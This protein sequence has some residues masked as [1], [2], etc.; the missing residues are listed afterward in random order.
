MKLAHTGWGLPFLLW[1][2]LGLAESPLTGF[3]SVA[4]GTFRSGDMV[5]DK[6]RHLVRVEQFEILDH[7]VTN[8]EYKQF[9]VDTGYRPPL[10]WVNGE[11]PD[12]K[13]NHPVVFVNIKDADQ[14]LRWLTEKEQRFYRLP[15]RVEFEYAARGGVAEKLYPWGDDDPAGRANYDADGGRRFDRWQDYLD[16]VRRGKPNGL[17]LYD[18]AGNVWQMVR[19]DV[20]PVISRY[21]YRFEDTSQSENIRGGNVVGG[22]WARGAEYLRCGFS[23]YFNMGNRHPD[24]GFRPVRE[25]EGADWRVEPRKLTALSKG[26]GQVFLSWARLKGDAK[27]TRFNVYRIDHGNHAGFLVNEKPLEESTTFLDTQREVGRRYTYYLRPVNREGQEG[28]CSERVGVTVSEDVRGVVATFRPGYVRGE[29]VPVFGDLDGDGALDCV[30]RLDN[31]NREMSQDL[32]IPVTLEAFT[33][34]GRPLWRREVCDHDHCF[35]NANNV[36]FGVWDM[37]GDGRAEVITRLQMGDDVVVAI[38]DGLTGRLKCNARWPDMVS[39]FVLSSTRI[40]LSIAYLDGRHPAVITQT[41]I[42]E[43]EVLNAFDAQLNPLWQFTSDGATSGSGGHKIEV[44]DVDGDGKQEV[45]DGTTCLR[46]DG[47]PRWSIYRMHPDVVSIHD[48]LPDRPGLEVFY[49]IESSVHAGAYMVDAS[50]GEVIWKHNRESDP[51]WD[52]GHTGATADLWDGSPGIECLGNRSRSGHLVLYSADGQILLEPFPA[53]WM[54]EWD[55]DATRELL[56]D[57]G[58]KIGNFDGRTIVEVPEAQPNPIPDS[59]FLMAADLCGDFRDELVLLTTGTDAAKT[60]TVVTATDPIDK[61]YVAPCEV[62]DYRLWLSRNMG[63]GYLSQYYQPL[64]SSGEN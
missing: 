52:H 53:Q 17:G 1:A 36:P 62:L 61:S 46:P 57:Q 4:G 22:S 45:F 8:Q 13:E 40:Q 38:L 7:P 26:Q 34:Y 47:T 56:I 23:L 59:T 21:V 12:G 9:I 39:D 37:D 50:S 60:I 44:A 11:I 29:L 16:P 10:H 54:I 35:G 28:R 30:V 5:T 43:N 20:D 31:G 25:P 3:V 55:G 32:G 14:Y 51:R 63:G 42:Y 49:L 41:G 6:E 18:M 27:S 2:S 15:T 64:V 48:F 33:S 19:D 24:L 58:R